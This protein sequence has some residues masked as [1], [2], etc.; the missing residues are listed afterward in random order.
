MWYKNVG[1]SLTMCVHMVLSCQSQ[2]DIGF[3]HSSCSQ[4]R[5]KWRMA[6]QDLARLQTWWG[7]P[8]Q[9]I[10]RQT[11]AK[12]PRRLT[13][14]PMALYR[15]MISFTKYS[16]PEWLDLPYALSNKW[17]SSLSGIVSLIV[18]QHF[19][20]CAGF[21]CA[22]SNASENLRW[23]PLWPHSRHLLKIRDGTHSFTRSVGT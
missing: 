13:S 14:S 3:H 20:N 5:D 17:N 23:N 2:Y 10:D 1:C 18:L 8:T 11:V 7:G 22:F 21:I 15:L 16:L 19:L 9:Q 12:T 4:G 6:I